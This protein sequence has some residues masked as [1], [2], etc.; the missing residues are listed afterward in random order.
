MPT[1]P[2]ES[3]LY[4]ELSLVDAKEVI[5][6]ASPLLQEV[7]NY[8]I[9]LFARCASSR[10]G[11]E[12]H[13]S[14]L[15]LYLHILE[16][17]DAVDILISQS[18]P[19]AAKL[20]LRSLFEALLSIEYLVERDYKQ[21]SGAWLVHYM[22][23][24][25]K[26]YDSWDPS[27]PRGKESQKLLTKDKFAT[28]LPEFPELQAFRM[29]YQQ[30]LADSEFVPIDQEYVRRR[31]RNW[32]QLFG[33]PSNLRELACHLG[34]G[35]QYDFLYRWWSSFAH[36]QE[37]ARFL[38]TTDSDTQ[39]LRPLR[40]PSGIGLVTTY[41]VTYSHTATKELTKKLRPGEE[42]HYVEWLKHEVLP[43]LQRL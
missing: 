31:P 25:L 35:G 20:P 5:A 23:Q 7:V 6:I 8:G 28:D 18:C 9:N 30:R 17:A 10:S 36:A 22:H 34:R 19:S 40:D 21:R 42:R 11:R 24:R 37:P 2:V 26:V 41:A 4:R 38:A 15:L 39:V 29:N 27:T 3:I 32:Y 14:L 1:K 12:E 16:M 33:G 43:L 13:F